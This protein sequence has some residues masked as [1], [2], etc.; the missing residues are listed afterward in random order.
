[1]ADRYFNP[2]LF[3]EDVP[4]RN[5]VYLNDGQEEQDSI[6]E[7]LR[8]MYERAEAEKE[9]DFVESF[10]EELERRLRAAMPELNLDILVYIDDIMLVGETG[11]MNAQFFAKFWDKCW[12][13]T[14]SKLPATEQLLIRDSH[15]APYLDSVRIKYAAIIFWTSV[16]TILK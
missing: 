15:L 14:S 7:D 12:F 4:V 2:S 9:E 13:R 6:L 11:E 8:Y 16:R 1:M 5:D 3:D 10:Q